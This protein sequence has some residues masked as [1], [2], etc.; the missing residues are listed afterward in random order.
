MPCAIQ[1]MGFFSMI[2]EAGLSE[3]N[4][5]RHSSTQFPVASQQ[6]CLTGPNRTNL[7]GLVDR[8]DSL[9]ARLQNGEMS[10]IPLRTPGVSREF[11]GARTTI[12]DYLDPQSRQ[13][14][15]RPPLKGRP[16]TNPIMENA[17]EPI[18][19]MKSAPPFVSHTGSSGFPEKETPCRA[20]SID[21]T[22]SE[23]LHERLVI[24]SGILSKQGEVESTLT[25]RPSVTLGRRTAHFRQDRRNVVTKV[26]RRLVHIPCLKRD[27]KVRSGKHPHRQTDA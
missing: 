13:R 21:S 2:P 20:S 27:P 25:R 7:A 14:F 5:K 12:L 24:Q 22:A 10:H 26:E 3:G 1:F 4:A 9:V 16:G 19:A 17:V 18:L 23:C 15:L 11:R 6:P 8:P